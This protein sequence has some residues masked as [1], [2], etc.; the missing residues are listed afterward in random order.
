[1]MYIIYGF[2]GAV[3]QLIQES[4]WCLEW[5]NLKVLLILT[6]F[7]NDPSNI[8]QISHVYSQA[9]EK[10]KV[11]KERCENWSGLQFYQLSVCFCLICH[12][13]FVYRMTYCQRNSRT[14]IPENRY[15]AMNKIYLNHINTF[16]CSKIFFYML[17]C[18]WHIQNAIFNTYIC[19]NV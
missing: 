2:S 16:L 19:L 10:I 7:A 5:T 14:T 18:F 8:K 17:S 9:K 4:L 3:W 15:Y 11:E 12:I 13:T 6:S 1:M